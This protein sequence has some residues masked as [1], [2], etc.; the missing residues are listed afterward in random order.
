MTDRPRTAS[1]VLS[2]FAAALLAVLT[3]PSLA[4]AQMP[5]HPF[6]PGTAF[7]TLSLPSLED[8]RPASIADF[9]GQRI[10]LHVFASW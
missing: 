9:R 6:Q 8:R 5:D 10:I 3:T 1:P 7:P 2:S 4:V